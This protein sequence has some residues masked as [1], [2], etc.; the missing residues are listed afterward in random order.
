[1]EYAVR[2]AVFKQISR[3]GLFLLKKISTFTLEKKTIF[4][5]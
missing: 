2:L 1:M 5:V 3:V 4:G